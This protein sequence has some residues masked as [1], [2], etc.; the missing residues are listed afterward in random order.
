MLA[1][2]NVEPFLAT[3]GPE[4][5]QA[6]MS[7]LAVRRWDRRTL[8][9]RGSMLAAG[10]TTL[11]LPSAVA[12]ASPLDANIGALAGFEEGSLEFAA[13]SS[14][15]NAL[16]VKSLGASVNASAYGRWPVPGGVTLVQVVAYSTSETVAAYDTES[17]SSPGPSPYAG[18]PGRGVQAVGTFVLPA[19]R[20]QYLTISFSGSQLWSSWSGGAGGSAVG[21]GLLDFQLGATA[22]LLV[23]GAGGGAGNA[24]VSGNPP[25]YDRSGTRTYA[26][27]NGGDAG[28]GTR[29]GVIAG[30]GGAGA[31]TSA[32]GAGGSG[33]LSIEGFVG[34]SPRGPADSSSGTSLG[35]GGTPGND[36]RNHPGGNGGGGLYGGGGGE[37][38]STSG[39]ASGAGGGGGGGSSYLNP[40]YLDGARASRLMLT[41]RAYDLG[42]TVAIY[43]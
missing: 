41:N 14:T 33:G 7:A 26:G 11:L 20:N 27:G 16:P 30:R 22:R 1:A 18:Q 13:N 40:T 32:P 39:L 24:G 10:V 3:L 37:T 21:V 5:A 12:A 25:V 28:A 36:A 2:G 9:P 34:G 4:V 31:T 15:L 19:D 29:D 38:D 35:R 42:P 8:L 6:V 43:W 23:A 17:A